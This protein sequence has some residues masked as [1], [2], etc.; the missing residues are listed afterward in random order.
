MLLHPCARASDLR[1][2][3]GKRFPEGL[4]VLGAGSL[5]VGHHLQ[6]AKYST[7][8]VPDSLKCR[9]SF[10]GLTAYYPVDVTFTN[11]SYCYFVYFT[12][13]LVMYYSILIG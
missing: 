11:D 6:Q 12:G 13:P 8:A 10:L 5:G 3:A 7:L 2:R 4:S 9:V 1:K